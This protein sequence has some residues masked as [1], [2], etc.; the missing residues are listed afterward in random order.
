MNLNKL[1]AASGIFLT[2]AAATPVVALAKHS[3]DDAAGQ[4]PRRPRRGR[5]PG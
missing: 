3:A 5:S 2:L 1:A 4:R